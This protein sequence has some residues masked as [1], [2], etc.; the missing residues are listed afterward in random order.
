MAK[1]FP[2]VPCEN[3]RISIE[4]L[5]DGTVLKLGCKDSLNV[6]KANNV[7]W[8]GLYGWMRI[9]MDETVPK[10]TKLKVTLAI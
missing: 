9:F 2:G 4:R 3:A 6:W 10:L 5:K 8:N 1:Y 7:P